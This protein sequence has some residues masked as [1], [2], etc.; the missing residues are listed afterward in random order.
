MNEL[1]CKCG[2]EKAWDEEFCPE[3]HK[4][5]NRI[6]FIGG[7]DIAAV[8]GLSRWKTPLQLWS[9]KTGILP[10]PDL[11]AVEAVELGSELEDFVAKKFERKTGLKVRRSPKYYSH[12]DF[13]MFTCQV[14]RLVENTNELLECKTCSSWKAK[15]WEGEEIPQEYILQVMWQLGITERTVGHIAVLIGG[16]A[17]KYKRIDFDL[18]MFNKMIEQALIF[19]KMVQWKIPPMAVADDNSFL[20][21]LYPESNDKLQEIE[22]LNQK[23]GYLQETKMH[24]KNMEEEKDE[25]EAEIKAVIGETLGIK[26]SQY[27][28]KWTPQQMTRLDTEKIKDDGLYSKYSKI[29][30]TRILRVTNNKGGK[31]E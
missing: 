5:K 21:E 10:L 12:K 25:L 27:I 23:I 14:D 22:E 13:T 15:E 7:S 18:E 8:M 30:K 4:I 9:E 29:T 19:W 16:Q 3:C 17:F 6:G 26:T 24:L 31:N 2:K 1:I 28:V 20:V 11:S